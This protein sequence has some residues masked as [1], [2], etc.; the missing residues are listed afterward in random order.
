MYTIL[1]FLIDTEMCLDGSDA[2]RLVSDYKVLIFPNSYEK[3]DGFPQLDRHAK[4]V[5]SPNFILDKEMV[6]CVSGNVYRFH[7]PGR[8]EYIEN[9]ASTEYSQR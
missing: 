2:R 9:I 7:Q 3:G 8:W 6:L 1:D 4:L 5:L